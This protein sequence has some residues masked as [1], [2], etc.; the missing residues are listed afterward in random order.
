MRR[1]RATSSLSMRARIAAPCSS[2]AEAMVEEISDIRPMVSPMS[3]MAPTDSWV[4]A[5]M[6]EIC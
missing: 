5:W 1:D 6:L 2:T 3:L 4:A